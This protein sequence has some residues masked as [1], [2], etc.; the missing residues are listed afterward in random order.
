MGTHIERKP[1]LEGKAA[2][3]TASTDGIGL[4]IATR[5]ATDGAK[6]MISSRKESNVRKVVSD[7]KEKGLSVEG[8]VCHV[9]KEDHR[10]NL[11]EETVKMF[12]GIDIL[13]SNAAVNP[14]MGSVLDMDGGVWDKIFDVNVKSAALLVKE[15]HPYLKAKN[16][17]SVVFISSIAGYAPSSYLGVY[18]ISKTALLGLTRTLAVEL[19]SDRI[20]VN[21]VAPGPFQTKF[22]SAIW[23]NES[24]LKVA[25]EPTLLKR[26]G[27]P[28]ECGGIVSYL[29]SDDSS[30]VTGETFVVAGGIQ[31][32]L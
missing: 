7:L 27:Q 6:V 1:P 25:L 21:C 26:I 23:K 24:T 31:S 4:A 3:V 18:S 28:E 16:N 2:I 30:Y 11:I 15:A 32:R 14:T 20:R 22:S 29:A 5:L 12:G 19:A 9:G 13:V 17:G 10:K 8:T